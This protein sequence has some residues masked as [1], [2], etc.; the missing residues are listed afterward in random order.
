HD[1]LYGEPDGSVLVR[2]EQ[3]LERSRLSEKTYAAVESALLAMVYS[4][5]L[6]RAAYWSDSLRDQAAARRSPGWEAIFAAARAE[7]ALRQG[8]LRSA[9]A[10]ARFALTYISPASSGLADGDSMAVM[11]MAPTTDGVV[12]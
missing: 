6:D 8:D 9:L 4:D 1:V 11:I 12:G 3:V 5:R 2:A 7:V 10:N